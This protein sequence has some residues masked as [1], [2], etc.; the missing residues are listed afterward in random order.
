MAASAPVQSAASNCS[1]IG[2]PP[3]HKGMTM[4]SRRA[5]LQSAAAASLAASTTYA[6]SSPQ[7]PLKSMTAGPKPIS[8]EERRERIARVQTLMAQRKIAALL[9]EPG[10]SLD[11]FTGIRWHRS[12]ERR[13]GKECR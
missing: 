3:H 1:N 12:E 2:A 11:Y 9:V 5:F 10:S 8:V 7:H 13:V 4:L 6:G